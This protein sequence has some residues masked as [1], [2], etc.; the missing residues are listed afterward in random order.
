MIGT[1]PSARMITQ[2][3]ATTTESNVSFRPG[4]AEDL[5]FLEDGS[6]DFV[7]AA[8]ASH[9]FDYSKVWPV[10]SRKLRKGGTLAFWGYKDNYFVEYPRA[11]KVL[12]HYCYT[13]GVG[14]MGE[15][16]EQPGRNILRDKLR[17]IVPPSEAFEDVERIEY[18]PDVKGR[19]SGVGEVLMARDMMLGEMEGYVRTFSA[20][21]NWMDANPGKKAR[22]DGGEGD[23]VDDMFDEMLRVE[24]EWASE[25]ERWREKVVASEWGSAILMARKR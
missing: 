14:L 21:T 23:V 1:D 11:T 25:G 8:Q 20:Y 7:S 18:E 9:W 12:D 5:D 17:E 2:A 15:F 3:Q 13:L 6:L 19:A 24:P 22:K 4:K 16:W 10:L